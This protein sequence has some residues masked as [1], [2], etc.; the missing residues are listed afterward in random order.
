MAAVILMLEMTGRSFPA[1]GPARN[2]PG[3]SQN[4]DRTLAG[5]LSSQRWIFR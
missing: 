1:N 5:E 4:G 2:R 3:R